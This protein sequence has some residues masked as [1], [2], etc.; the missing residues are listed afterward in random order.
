MKQT[1]KRIKINLT[2]IFMIALALIIGTN[3]SAQGYNVESM[4]IE[5]EDNTKNDIDRD[6]TSLLK[7]ASDAK[8]HPKTA[9]SEKMWYY[10][11]VLYLKIA[12][13]N[14]DLSA[15]NPNA[16]RIALESFNKAI[17]GDVKE[18]YTKL[19]QGNLL[20]VAIGLYQTGYAFYTAGDYASSYKDFADAVPLM[21]YDVDGELKRKNLTG[22]F[23]EQWMA[24]SA[25][26]NNE[27]QK[28]IAVFDKLI[29]NGSLEPS[30]YVNVSKLYL[31]TGDT[32]KALE[33]ITTGRGL[34]DGDKSLI[35]AELDLYLKM[36]RSEELI[37][38]L[39]VAIADDPGNTIYY[40][41]R[42]ISFEG[43][44]DMDKASADYDKIL[45]I[46]P[47]FYD[48]AYNKGVMFLNKVAKIVEQ[49]NGEYKPSIIAKKEAEINILY[50]LAII[51]F[52]NVF[53]NNDEMKLGDKTELA[54]T[55]KKI[56]AR[57]ER[58]E[59]YNEMKAFEEAN[60]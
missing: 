53:Q 59:K 38:K 47:T 41:A 49:L 23:L 42:A 51:Q 33:A 9:N 11:G 34:L 48:A 13:L 3:A 27:D 28:A 14:N 32:A 25:M 21:Q 15:A 7:W 31:K 2:S 46:D 57:L 52:E 39:D 54:G 29:K 17:A 22:E 18:K 37:E 56:Y 4:K 8:E 45:E 55:M 35:N 58:M 30:V 40:F 20:N 44:G 43:I 5:L 36:G 10:R 60:K 1:M 26:N 6:Y 16:I 24:Y 19:A 50:D 12:S